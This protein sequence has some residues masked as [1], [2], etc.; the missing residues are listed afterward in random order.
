MPD[1]TA[2]VRMRNKRSI[3]RIEPKDA[4]RIFAKLERLMDDSGELAA[5]LRRD[6]FGQFLNELEEPVLELA[7][8]PDSWGERTKARLVSG[9]MSGLK[10]MRAECARVQEIVDVSNV[11]MPCFLLE[12]GRRKGHVAAEFPK[13]PCEREAH[14]GLGVALSRPMHSVTSEQIIR[15][16]T[17]F[18][19]D[20]VGLC[21]F[22]DRQ[23]RD[24]IEADLNRGEGNTTPKGRP[25]RTVASSSPASPKPKH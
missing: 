11:V 17:E 18:G 7:V 25:C 20:L 9:I 16:V 14:F 5:K 22:G 12:L 13:D 6:G 8:Q 1:F 21:Y 3:P 24:V 4:A 15:L 2:K 23:S 19:A 10:G